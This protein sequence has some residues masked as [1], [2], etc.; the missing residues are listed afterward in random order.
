M[1]EL[2][3]SSLGCA[4]LC[5]TLGRYNRALALQRWQFVLNAPEARALES[6][7][8]RIELDTAL[9][10]QALDAAE[11][12]RDA[13]RARDA[14]TVLRVALSVLEEA[15]ADRLTRL[16]AMAVYSRMVRAIRPLPTPSP[17]P[18]RSVRLKALAAAG[19]IVHGFLVGTQERFRLWLVLMGLG[20]RIVLRGGRRAVDGASRERRRAWAAFA[21]G[22]DDFE[23]LDASHLAAF[24]A[25]AASLSAVDRG[26][27]LELWERIAGDSR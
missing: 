5:F 2:L 27:R 21:A 17:A 18:F 23:A 10:R 9:A 7:R 22:L 14:I 20:V 26:G 6:L 8:R 13:S 16:R 24:E 3:L 11:R 1:L 4:A 25:L 19:G 15:G 12:A